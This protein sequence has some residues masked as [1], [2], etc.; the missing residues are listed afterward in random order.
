MSIVLEPV[1]DAGAGVRVWEGAQPVTPAHARA[2]K[3]RVQEFRP[4]GIRN[5]TN[6][7]L[8]E[9]QKTQSISAKVN[10]KWTP[11]VTL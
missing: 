3:I 11:S 5:N 1:D 2:P 9:K 6:L 8:R 4:D 7:V 10:V